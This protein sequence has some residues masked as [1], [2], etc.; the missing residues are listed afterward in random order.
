GFVIK[1]EVKK[2]MMYKYKTTLHDI[3]NKLN[4][5]KYF[6][7]PSPPAEC[8]IYIYPNYDNISLPKS[9]NSDEETW[10]Y[11]YTRDVCID[12]I[13]SVAICGIPG[14]EQIFYA[15]GSKIDVQGNNFVELM[16]NVNVDFPTLTTD[17]VWEVYEHL[18]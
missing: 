10:R 8:V 16:K 18:G 15:N 12:D 4:I 5:D 13:Q 14:I 3:V 9:I 1:C 7:V 11:Y 6:A 2:E 17:V